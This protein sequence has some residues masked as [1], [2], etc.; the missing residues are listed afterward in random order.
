M[1]HLPSEDSEQINYGAYSHKHFDLGPI[2][3]EQNEYGAYGQQQIYLK[4]IDYGTYGTY[5]NQ[6]ETVG[7]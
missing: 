2:N 5:G 6:L 4:P 7:S 1:F 3:N